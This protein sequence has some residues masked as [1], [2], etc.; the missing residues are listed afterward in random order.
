[1]SEPNGCCMTGTN[2]HANDKFAALV[3]EEHGIRG[4]N[5]DPR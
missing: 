1:M 5:D 2:D 4:Q 3:K